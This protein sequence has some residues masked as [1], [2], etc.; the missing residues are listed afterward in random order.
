V[1]KLVEAQHLE[2]KMYRKNVKKNLRQRKK[3][4]KFYPEE[5]VGLKGQPMS[6]KRNS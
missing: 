3:K 6:N 4:E 1:R 2:D 5:E